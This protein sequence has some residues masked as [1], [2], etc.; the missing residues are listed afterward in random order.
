MIQ[1]LTQLQLGKNGL[2]ESFIE[3]LK[4][5]FKKNKSVRISVLK[6]ARSNGKSSVKRYAEEILENLGK[7]Y[8]AKIIGFVIVVRKGKI[9]E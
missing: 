4:N 2:T 9:I 6:S 5:H 3:S 7:N 1:K 8:R